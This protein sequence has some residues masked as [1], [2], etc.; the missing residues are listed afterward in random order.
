VTT[1]AQTWYQKMEEI[2]AALLPLANAVVDIVDP[3]V[4]GAANQLSAEI[5]AALNSLS[6]AQSMVAT[7]DAFETARTKPL[8]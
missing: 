3:A 6:K 1:P 4:A 5:Q 8:W 2:I 7:Q